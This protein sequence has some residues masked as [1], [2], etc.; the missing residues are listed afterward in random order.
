[1]SMIRSM[2]AVFFALAIAIAGKSTCHAEGC[3]LQYFYDQPTTWGN[4][5]GVSKNDACQNG[6]CFM[7]NFSADCGFTCN[8]EIC[9]SGGD[10]TC[11]HPYLQYT[12]GPS[13]WPC[14]V[15]RT[16]MSECWSEGDDPVASACPAGVTPCPSCPSAPWN[17]LIQN[18][19]NGFP[20]FTTAHSL[21]CDY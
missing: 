14:N 17:N 13:N 8:V 10:V 20:T 11:K 16:I 6:E 3:I 12:S 18:W 9:Y 19:E 2:I 21:T 1:M 7:Y 15:T 4:G 5:G